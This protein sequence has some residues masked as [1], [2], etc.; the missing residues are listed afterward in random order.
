MI[1]IIKD[2]NK[3]KNIVRETEKS[4]EVDKGRDKNLW[5]G[6]EINIYQNQDQGKKAVIVRDRRIN[7]EIEIDKDRNKDKGKDK[8]KNK[9]KNKRRNK[10]KDKDKDRG[11]KKDKNRKNQ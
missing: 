5:T 10:N 6:N 1:E 2:Q 9:N 11:K 8:G 7:K 3:D 4:R